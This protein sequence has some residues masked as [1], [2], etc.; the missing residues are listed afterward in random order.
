MKYRVNGPVS[1]LPEFAGAF[2]CSPPQP[3]AR[4]NDQRVVIW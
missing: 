1:N 3:M 4:P 2:Q